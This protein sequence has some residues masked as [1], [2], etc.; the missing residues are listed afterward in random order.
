M[1][2]RKTPDFSP[3]I[4]GMFMWFTIFKNHEITLLKQL[5]G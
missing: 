3:E 1:A 4:S 5:E 2:R